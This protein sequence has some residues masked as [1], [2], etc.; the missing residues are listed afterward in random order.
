[1]P[2][3]TVAR[4]PD[5]DLGALM[6]A[7]MR[8]RNA[9]AEALGGM[10]PPMADRPPDV[11]RIALAQAAAQWTNAAARALAGMPPQVVDRLSDDN[12]HALS[13]AAAQESERAARVLAG[14]PPHVAERLPDDDLRAFAQAAAQTLGDLTAR[15]RRDDLAKQGVAPIVA[16]ADGLPTDIA[17]AQDAPPFIIPEARIPSR[18]ALSRGS[19]GIEGEQGHSV[20]ESPFVHAIPSHGHLVS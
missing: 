14:M 6:Q 4:L 3:H 7:V 18:S 16:A 20:S 13:Q 11:D 2:P 8:R 9:A 1:M 5:A 17:W 19:D 10:P 15:L 12:L